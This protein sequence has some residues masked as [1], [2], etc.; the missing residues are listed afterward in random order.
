[1]H[2]QIINYSQC[3]EDPAILDEA[4]ETHSED[5]MLSVTSGG[6]N[7]LALLLKKPQQIISIDSN[8]AQTYLLQLKIAAI[9][10][11][12]HDELLEFLGVRKSS[13]RVTLFEKVEKYLPVEATSW[14]A[15]HQSFI[16]QGVI[17]VGR[18]ERFLNSFSRYV[19]PLIHSKKTTESF[20][21]TSSLQS[22]RDFYKN[23]WNS[24]RWRLFFRVITSRF[25]LKSFA[26]Q[27]GMFTHTE[28]GTIA[29]EYLK[30]LDQNFNMVPIKDNYFMHFCLTDNY[31]Q[32][33]PPYL[34]AEELM[35]LK[36]N[37]PRLS[38]VTNDLTRYLQSMPDDS[39][40]KFNLSDVFEP[41]SLEENDTLWQEIIRTA[42]NGAR[43]VY[44]NNLVPRS[45]PQRFS[46]NI[47]DDAQLASRL[48]S[49]D[50]VFFYGSFHVN[51][52]SK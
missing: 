26:R 49:T 4:L 27:R 2:K 22:Q 20:L 9:Q 5:A 3:W 23:V 13:Q 35:S 37:L 41:L 51:T 7:T 45:F 42:K 16:Q 36:E 10:S 48:H 18:F 25:V 24:K 8:A 50:R 40:S 1:M 29:K 43:V 32:S 21:H 39:F 44:W 11:L 47:R 52:I 38:I 31:G 46:A 6:D 14:W 19:L 28:S 30:R 34:E 33:M 15:N 17:H 12:H